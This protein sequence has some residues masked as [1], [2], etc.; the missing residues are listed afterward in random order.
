MGRGGRGREPDT[1]GREKQSLTFY[2]FPLTNKREVINRRSTTRIII[3]THLHNPQD[4]SRCN[5]RNLLPAR[6]TVNLLTWRSGGA[7]QSDNIF[8]LK[9]PKLVFS[10]DLIIVM[11]LALFVFSLLKFKE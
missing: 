4:R 5:A 11:L 7:V 3:P 10:L 8:L 6:L 9:P 2:L 1:E